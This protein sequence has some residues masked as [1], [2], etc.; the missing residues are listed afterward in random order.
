MLERLAVD[1]TPDMSRRARTHLVTI[2]FTDIVGSSEIAVEVGDRRWKALLEAHHAIV[3]RALRRH[4]GKELDTAGD[5]FFAVFDRQAEAIRCA[6]EIVEEVRAIGLEV[7]AGLHMGEAELIGGKVG[8]VAVHTGARVGAAGGP[9]EVVVSS[10]LHDLVPGAGIDFDDL[11]SRRFKGVPDE[12]RIW[13]VRSVNGVDLAEPLKAE[14][15]AERRSR[16][17]VPPSRRPALIAGAVAGIVVLAGLVAFLVVSGEK[18]KAQDSTIAPIQPNTLLAIDPAT[19][20]IDRRYHLSGPPTELAY[21]QGRVWV[22]EKGLLEVLEPKSGK[23][24]PPIG[25]GFEAC[26]VAPSSEGV[27]VADCDH[28]RL[29]RVDS[30]A[31]VKKWVRVPRGRLIVPRETPSGLW[32][33]SAFGPSDARLSNVDPKTGG[34]LGRIVI[35]D[36][37]GTWQFAESEGFL[38]TFDNISGQVLRITPSTGAQDEIESLSLPIS[39]VENGTWI[40]VADDGPNVTLQIDPTN[41]DVVDRPNAVGNLIATPDGVWALS[42]HTLTRINNEGEITGKI[43]L[44]YVDVG[45][46]VRCGLLDHSS[47]ANPGIFGA[48]EVWIGVRPEDV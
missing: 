21:S 7:R 39:I 32:V 15:A 22:I 48:G 35:P 47:C 38:W 11:G 41:G 44:P 33:L 8:G 34:V 25:L 14:E 26:S 24:W 18:P 29:Y 12:V 42:L 43:D 27:I 23:M 19:M 4:G 30:D 17:P 3:R 16:V 20:Q 37:D 45:G 2:L 46:G 36:N 40:W 31:E 28:H 5:G 9:G 1:D 13:S 10:V 6:V